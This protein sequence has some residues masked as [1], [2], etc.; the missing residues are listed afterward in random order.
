MSEI[1]NKIEILVKQHYSELSADKANQEMG[2]IR[3]SEPFYDSREAMNAIRTILGGWISQ[4]PNVR[5]FER[6]FSQYIG[7]D[8]GIAVNSGSSANLLALS[9]L[10][11][12]YD[13]PDGAEVIV[14]AATFATVSMPIQRE[15]HSGLGVYLD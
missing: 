11:K 6:Q 10:K 1:L 14:P 15:Q 4:G 12:R 7:T 8:H 5:K 2:Q 13:I 3:L 9:A